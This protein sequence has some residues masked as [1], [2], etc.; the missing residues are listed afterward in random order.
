MPAQS[1]IARAHELNAEQK[2]ALLT[3][4]ISLLTFKDDT[5]YGVAPSLIRLAPYLGPKQKD[6][7]FTALFALLSHRHVCIHMA[8]LAPYLDIKKKGKLLDA[9]I[10]SLDNT[11]VLVREAATHALG[12]LLPSLSNDQ[13]E[14]LLK[15]TGSINFEK[16]VVQLFAQTELNLTALLKKLN[17]DSSTQATVLNTY[18]PTAQV[19][20][21]TDQPQTL[22]APTVAL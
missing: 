8:A 13:N 16:Q 2:N 3:T 9:L 1:L 14:S 10:L 22:S 18:K 15:I 7:L 17:T 21:P 5:I 11:N 19:E 20:L 4:Y 6:R 12:A